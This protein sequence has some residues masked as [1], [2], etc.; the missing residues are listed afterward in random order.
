M[1]YKEAGVDIKA[2]EE[3]AKH[4]KKLSDK[5]GGFGGLFEVPKGYMNPMLVGSVDSV[6][7][8]LKIA[9][10]L[11]IH[12]T[13][14]QDIVNHCVNDILAVGAAP[15]YFMD[16]IGTSKL[17]LKDQKGVIEGVVKACEENGIVLL[18]G[19]TAELPGFYNP[20]EYDLVGSITGIVEKK[21]V[22]DG[23]GIIAGD[24]L[25]AL[26][27]NGLHTNGYSL[28]RGIIED[29]KLKLHT[30]VKDFG[31]TLGEELL[32]V[33]RSYLDV[34]LP[35]IQNVK[36]LIHVTGGGFYGNIPRVLPQGIG[37][38]VDKNS[39]EIPPIF[40]FIQRE[41]DV[42]EEEM[43][44]VF[45]MGAGMIAVVDDLSLFE[46]VKESWVIGET[47]ETGKVEIG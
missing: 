4:I 44:N 40:E 30:Y 21:N 39:W 34:I 15:L 2:G 41:G 19:E 43:F 26:P 3:F 33:H 20:A 17:D 13:I 14:G 38:R 27:S 32:R 28:V 22:I 10:Q 11:G 47:T 12:N 23:E 37:A 29:K 8:K 18:G 25:V 45:N 1:K 7:T 6:G 42:E 36:G 46:G 9:F 35:L 24:K 31:H 5:V 16:Y